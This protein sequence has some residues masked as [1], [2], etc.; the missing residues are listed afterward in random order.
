MGLVEDEFHAVPEFLEDGGGFDEDSFTVLEEPWGVLLRDREGDA[1]DLGHRLRLHA[2][3]LEDEPV[4]LLGDLAHGYAEVAAPHRFVRDEFEI[5]DQRLKLQ[6]LG[7]DLDWPDLHAEGEDLVAHMRRGD[8]EAGVV[9][10][11]LGDDFVGSGY[12]GGEYCV[13]LFLLPDIYK[14]SVAGLHPVHEVFVPLWYSP[15]VLFFEDLPVVPVGG[16][17]PVGHD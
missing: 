8:E 10:V 16:G 1:G 3:P 4:I 12:R 5:P 11:G 2:G 14:D 15:Y 17:D 9:F 13:V 7:K 6:R